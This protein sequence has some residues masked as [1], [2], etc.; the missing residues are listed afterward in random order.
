MLQITLTDNNSLLAFGDYGVTFDVVA[1]DAGRGGG[2]FQNPPQS[3]KFTLL[4][5][6][7]LPKIRNPLLGSPSDKNVN[8][9]WVNAPSHKD[10]FFEKCI[11][12]FCL[13]PTTRSAQY[14]SY[15]TF[16]RRREQISPILPVEHATKIE[17][18][19]CATLEKTRQNYLKHLLN[20]Q[21]SVP[22]ILST[23]DL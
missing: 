18:A 15:R 12:F 23:N 21:T 10:W 17:G 9:S 20:N 7:S 19:F 5:C 6:L 11:R 16:S 3:W 1:E 22:F 4:R 14:S 2:S 8:S 13:D